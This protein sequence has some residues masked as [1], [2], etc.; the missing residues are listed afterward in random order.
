MTRRIASINTC[1]HQQAQ[2]SVP[3]DF[4]AYGRIKTTTQPVRDRVVTNTG[5]SKMKK[6]QVFLG[7]ALLVVSSVAF[8]DSQ[9][10][11]AGDCD[12]TAIEAKLDAAEG[13]L[14]ALESK[15]DAAEG[16]LDSLEAKAD[17]H[18]G[19]EDG[20]PE[21]SLFR[22][23]E[24]DNKKHT[25]WAGATEGMCINVRARDNKNIQ[26]NCG[27]SIVCVTDDN[28]TEAGKENKT[29]AGKEINLFWT[30]PEKGTD[31][32]TVCCMA[33][34]HGAQFQATCVGTFGVCRW[35]WNV[36]R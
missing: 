1:T 31:H 33:G 16:K 7:A 21:W 15:S 18:A 6:Y 12:L 23:M 8:A 13:K 22:A 19:G 29:E 30:Q 3:A 32:G 11:L 27:I 36:A 28:K 20:D 24:C 17:D 2:A 26:S 25:G 5:E 4:N 9:Q 14:D 10:E 35:S 34:K